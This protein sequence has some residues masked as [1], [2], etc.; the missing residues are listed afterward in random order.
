MF[1][2]A[3]MY[4]ITGD[5]QFMKLADMNFK[6][7]LDAR[8]DPSK[9][10]ATI[11]INW[12]RGYV[13]G[14]SGNGWSPETPGVKAD[15]MLGSIL[16]D[17]L[18]NCYD[19]MKDDD[20]LK[21]K[22]HELLTRISEFMLR[23][24]YF[25]G[26]KRG[27]WAYWIPYIYNLTDREKSEPGHKLAGQASFW[28]V[29]PYVETGERKWLTQMSKMLKMA[30]WDGDGVWGTYG[31]IDHPGYQ[32][33]AYLVLKDALTSNASSLASRAYPQ[34]KG[35]TDSS[36][37]KD[38][39]AIS[40]PRV[41]G[42]AS[43]TP[44]SRRNTLRTPSSG[45]SY[46]DPLDALLPGEWYEVPNSRLADVAPK[47]PPG[48]GTSRTAAIMAAW[49]GGAYDT[50]RQRLVIW[51]G[52]HADY[53]GNEIY[54]FDINKLKW[55][56]LTNPSPTTLY[57]GKLN[58]KAGQKDLRWNGDGTPV[59][60][61]TYD[62]IQYIPTIDRFWAQGGSDWC[63]GPSDEL[64]WTFDFE[65]LQWQRKADAP[66]RAG[67][68]VSAYDPV[69]GHIFH[70]G[71]SALME[72][73]P[74]AD[75]WQTRSRSVW[76][77]GRNTAEVDP[78]RRRFIMIGGGKSF[79]YD[80][81]GEG[82]LIRKK[83]ETSG[84]NEIVNC[85]APGLVY[86]PLIDKI[87]AW[88]GASRIIDPATKK[89]IVSTI[90]ACVYTLNLDTFVWTKYEPHGPVRPPDE[91]KSMPQGTYGRWQYIPSKDAFIGVN[92]VNTNVYFYKLPR[93]GK[94][95]SSP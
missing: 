79:F 70:H 18:L 41:L 36:S 14:G 94:K 75:K 93:E 31:Y 80:L 49:S 43:Q 85:D 54:V 55:Q 84:D 62:G 63:L 92:S 33:M 90:G 6:R 53:A 42:A 88:C 78:V 95:T 9:P 27:H 68:P 32:T 64:T 24:P 13:A 12:E 86:D 91:M 2:L 16:Y 45:D 56:R 20:P 58:E 65:S 59:S 46:V 17:G 28:T 50:K 21:A 74:I 3:A 47:P 76:Q 67:T 30:L 40:R 69:T 35:A 37:A 25:E 22:A 1:S 19:Y 15:L 38:D 71:Q 23:E 44:S 81:S 8:F 7:L 34:G 89:K 57:C 61:H 10:R 83:L 66:M 39:P 48:G 26:T 52:G 82:L 4:E 51:G 77:S 11:F 87:V 73:D 60:R 72:Y 29:T 5:G